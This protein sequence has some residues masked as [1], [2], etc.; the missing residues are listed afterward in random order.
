MCLFMI[1]KVPKKHQ[2]IQNG[3]AV[4]EVKD[5]LWLHFVINSVTK[6]PS[7]AKT[8]LIPQTPNEISKKIEAAKIGNSYEPITTLEIQETSTSVLLGFFFF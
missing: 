4:Q 3:K 2:Q 8:I 7:Y 6:E 1:Y 5:Q